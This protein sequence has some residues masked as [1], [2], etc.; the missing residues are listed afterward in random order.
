M[1]RKYKVLEMVRKVGL[2]ILGVALFG[3]GLVSQE[4][5]VHRMRVAFAD[6]LIGWAAGPVKHGGLSGSDST[7]RVFF[8]TV[9]LKTNDG[10]HTWVLQTVIQ[11]G[12]EAVEIRDLFVF[13][14]KSCWVG[15]NQ[16]GQERDF[17]VL[18]NDGIKWHAAAFPFP[19]M[20]IKKIYFETAQVGWILAHE[21]FGY[22]RL[23][24]SSD[25]G[26][27][28]HLE[29][30]PF[31]GQLYDIRFERG[32]GYL[33]AGLRNKPS[34]M[35][36]LRSDDG[37]RI[38]IEA[39]EIGPGGNV[40]MEDGRIFMN[41]DTVMVAGS[42]Y[43]RDDPDRS[44]T[45][46]YVSSDRFVSYEER[47]IQYSESA[48]GQDSWAKNLDLVNGTLYAVD[49][50]L[51]IESTR[52]TR[53]ILSEDM[54]RS[55]RVFTEM[56][57]PG[58]VVSYL[59]GS[60]H[61]ASNDDGELSLLS[62]QGETPADMDFRG[63]FRQAP[64]TELPA[65]SFFFYADD[66]FEKDS[67]YT[68]RWEN[69]QDSLL[70]VQFSAVADIK[71]YK[72]DTSR[73]F[74]V[75]IDSVFSTKV[76]LHRRVRWGS[77][78]GAWDLIKEE[79][80]AGSIVIRKYQTMRL[81]G[82]VHTS[83]DRKVI[84][85]SWSSSI[86]GELS[87]EL[88]FTTHPKQLV[89]GTHFIFFKALDDRGVWSDP[90]V[91]KVV[92][93]DFPKIKFPFEGLWSAG[94]TGSYYNRGHHIRGIRFALDLNYQ[95]G[96][97]GGDSDYGLPVRAST[98]GVVSFAGYV[99]GYG[100]MVKVDYFYGGHKYT[101]LVS[102]LSAI[103]VDIGEQ[104]R[105]GQELGTCGSTGRSSAPHIHWELRVDDVCTPPEPIFLND[106]VVVQT[107]RDGGVYRSE[108]HY[109]PE[110]IIVVDDQEVANTFFN[111]KGYHH[112]YRY[113][114]ITN[115]VKTVEMVWRPK[116]PQSGFYKIQVMI[117]K[118]YATVIAT[119]KLHTS[120]GV[121][122][123]KVNQNK[124]TE[125]WITLATVELDASDDVFVSLDNV[126]TQRRG[127]IAFDAVR[128]IGLWENPR[129]GLHQK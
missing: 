12:P 95:E 62:E 123:Y 18:T 120:A 88:S 10:G 121:R 5:T 129:M 72:V 58:Y 127:T 98:D 55:W 48:K 118:K 84:Q 81:V 1:E 69:E 35:T 87:K 36:V 82:S 26:M 44:F 23:Y 77:K 71:K 28:W 89:A 40:S 17:L 107:I 92:V 109:E 6:S 117:P 128:F 101:T 85:Y 3:S 116:L 33:T 103:S 38:W 27:N 108:N 66:D 29:E 115:S 42:A 47:R 94:G 96:R 25:G 39:S 91:I 105:Q 74:S 53:M 2:V 68:S 99:R 119:Y 30:F 114:Y 80:V 41:G 110:N 70:A 90:V 59:P 15:L 49:K 32:H 7:S 4:N 60:E 21:P 50:P 61:V 11:S 65:S 56:K 78:H 102:H 24:R 19:N 34:K 64:K 73:D 112:S 16:S 20:D 125:E 97:D 100:R 37:G 93:E 9:L 113:S 106:S 31:E 126:T 111:P 22:D 76:Y 63:I 54:G 86:N 79:A 46:F 8:N 45:S 104:V 124:F 75:G 43:D 67:V 57:S 52:E 51:E 14:N 83:D 122:E 13:D